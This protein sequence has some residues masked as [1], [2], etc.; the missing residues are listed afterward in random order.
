MLDFGWEE[1][2]EENK[3]IEKWLDSVREE[4]RRREKKKGEDEALFV[5]IQVF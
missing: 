5:L 2:R 3:K 4:E 1:V